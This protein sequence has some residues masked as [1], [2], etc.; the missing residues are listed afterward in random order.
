ME[1]LF[2]EQ[3]IDRNI[4]YTIW[5]EFYTIY[6][7]NTIVGVMKIGNIMPRVGIEPTSPAFHVSVITI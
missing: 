6:G 7:K 5:L 3:N 1:Q 2:E 4:S